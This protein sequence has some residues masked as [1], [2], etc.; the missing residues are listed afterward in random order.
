MSVGLSGFVT[1]AAIGPSSTIG[2]DVRSSTLPERNREA[3]RQTTHRDRKRTAAGRRLL[4]STKLSHLPFCSFIGKSVELIR[5]S[6]SA[7]I[8]SPS[9]PE[10]AKNSKRRSGLGS[11]S[12]IDRSS[13]RSRAA[14]SGSRISRAYPF[15]RE[16]TKQLVVPSSTFL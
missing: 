11:F 7:A 12:M 9:A 5:V 2:T 16:A 8:L 1:I 3:V 15:A 10:R 6:I 14:A 4:I 13:S